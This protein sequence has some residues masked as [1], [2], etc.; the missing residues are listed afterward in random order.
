LW[1]VEIGDLI[2]GDRIFQGQE[3]RRMFAVAGA[4]REDAAPV[5]ENSY[6]ITPGTEVAHFQ[7]Q[8]AIEIIAHGILGIDTGIDVDLAFPGTRLSRNTGANERAIQINAMAAAAIGNA[9]DGHGKL[10]RR[11]AQ[12]TWTPRFGLKGIA[13]G[14]PH[15]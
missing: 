5:D 14:I 3:K 4:V 9:A 13:A 1:Y 11:R 8:I 7:I 15:L 12:Q 10:V 6:R 2:A